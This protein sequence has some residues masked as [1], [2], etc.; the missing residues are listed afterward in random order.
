MEWW[1][2]IVSGTVNSVGMSCFTH[3]CA[4]TMEICV[5][6]MLESEK[7][8]MTLA[9]PYLGD[10]SAFSMSLELEL[11]KVKV[12]QECSYFKDLAGAGGMLC[13]CFSSLGVVLL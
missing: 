2:E 3:A 13:S 10:S 9:A 5:T 11:M 12:V 4:R 6:S 1:R 7:A 8:E